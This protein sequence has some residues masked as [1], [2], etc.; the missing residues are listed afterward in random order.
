MAD[1]NYKSNSINLS[2]LQDIGN[3]T[4]IKNY[5]EIQN[6]NN[7][8]LKKMITTL[9]NIINERD[10]EIQKL[11]NQLDT[12]QGRL[13]GYVTQQ[14][15]A[16]KEQYAALF[17]E[18]VSTIKR[19]L[20]SNIEQM[21]NNKMNE[22]EETFVKSSDVYSKEQIDDLFITKTEADNTFVKKT[23]N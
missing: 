20:T 10:E 16:I 1:F 17:Q 11:K 8:E 3:S 22:F 19:N 4:P 15:D 13:K 18:E 23:N 21:F 7:S 2:D 5:P 12:I 9:K 14:V 6:A